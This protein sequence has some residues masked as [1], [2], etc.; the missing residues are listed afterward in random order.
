[1][2]DKCPLQGLESFNTALR[3]ASRLWLS[4]LEQSCGAPEHNRLLHGAENKEEDGGREGE[5]C[6]S[7]ERTPRKRPSLCLVEFMGRRDASEIV[8]LRRGC[9]EQTESRGAQG[10]TCGETR[11]EKCKEGK[12]TGGRD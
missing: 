4:W 10:R 2:C 7:Y 6:V 12:G 9:G 5:F 11:E 8:G 3:H 1:M